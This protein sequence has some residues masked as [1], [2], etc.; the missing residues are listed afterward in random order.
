MEDFTERNKQIVEYL[1]KR[2]DEIDRDYPR[3]N[4]K[5]RASRALENVLESQG[6]FEEI[7]N[8]LDKTLDKMIEV[9]NEKQSSRVNDEIGSREV[10]DKNIAN[11]N[12]FIEKELVFGETYKTP[13]IEVFEKY[14]EIKDDDVLTNKKEVF[15]KEYPIFLSILKQKY[16]ALMS[17]Q[18]KD[19]IRKGELNGKKEDP[20]LYVM[21]DL[22]RGFDSLNY[23][24]VTNLYNT[25]IN[26]VSIVSTD[27]DNNMKF[28]ING[29]EALYVLPDGSYYSNDKYFDFTRLVKVFKFAKKHNK[30]VRLHSFITPDY[31]PEGLVDA[32]SKVDNKDKFIMTFLEDYLNHM[33]ASLKTSGIIIDQIDVLDRIIGTEDNFWSKYL[34]ANG[35]NFYIDILKLVK[36]V[37]PRAEL[38]INESNEYLDYICDGFCKAIRSIQNLEKNTNT[39]LLDGIGL[40]SHIDEFIEYYGRE[41][42]GSDLYSTMVQYASFGLPIYR[43]EFDYKV[44]SENL[45]FSKKEMLDIIDYI[46][47]KCNVVGFI[48]SLNSDS[49]TT[50]DG[51][52][53]E[54]HLIDSLGV[55]KEEYKMF[56]NRYGILNSVPSEPEILTFGDSDETGKNVVKW[57]SGDD[58]TNSIDISDIS[59][60]SS[61]GFTSS[62]FVILMVFLFLATLIISAI[63]LFF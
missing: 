63:I 22:F 13:L 12:F 45:E 28:C 32:I 56:K 6:S 5:S 49:L 34:D 4:V 20:L 41:I 25:F 27:F 31:I 15:D 26:D 18:M 55:P 30:K 14:E 23:D 7:K 57:S 44:M 2:M 35:Y 1:N 62:I 47:K 37:L 9:F 19:D 54:V 38:I 51:E 43:T 33:L 59:T 40:S 52:F 8:K 36:K 24:I 16:K 48:L 58:N 60:D 10:F 42:K 21:T 53:N 11:F 17:S 39:K 3:I 61:K 29:N 50:K 46:D